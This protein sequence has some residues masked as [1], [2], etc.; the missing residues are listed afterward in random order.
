MSGQITREEALKELERGFYSSKRE[1]EENKEYV[2]KKLGLTSEEFGRIMNLPPKSYKDYPNNS[3]F[4]NR[5][6]FFIRATRHILRRFIAR[7]MFNKTLKIK[8]R[9]DVKLFGSR[10]DEIY[11]C[12]RRIHEKTWTKSYISE[13]LIKS[14]ERKVLIDRISNCIP[15]ESILEFGCASGPNLYLLTRKFPKAK[16]YGIDISKKAIKEGK[17]FLKKWA[18][19]ML[20]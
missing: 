4:L 8:K 15:F 2:I 17:K 18:L 12:F 7:I 19:I 6:G 14:P 13:K 11:W 3:L 16:I 9:I 20:S 10:V 1:M 5:S